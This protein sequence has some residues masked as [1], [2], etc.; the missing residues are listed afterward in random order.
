MG[1]MK[2]IKA[3]ERSSAERV[4]GVPRTIDEYLAGVPE[5]AHSTLNKVRAAIRSA[6]PKDATEIISYR[7]PA[8][9]YKGMLVWFAA[10]SNHCSFFP[11]ASVVEAF[12]PQLKGYSLAKGTIQF[13][14]DKP[15]PA[16]LI[17]KMVQMRVAQNE[18]KNRR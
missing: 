10:F 9:R 6:A 12:K 17:R 4:A 2:R 1:D 3:R 11:T 7:M 13:P 8:F 5:P 15:L 14:T 18:K 16:G